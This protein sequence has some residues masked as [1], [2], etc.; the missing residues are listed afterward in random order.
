MNNQE[1]GQILERI[2]ALLQLSD[3]N[4]FKIRAYRQAAHS[5][6]NL[7]C[8]LYDLYAQ[9]RLREISGVGKTV[10]AHIEEILK[11]GASAY[12]EELSRQIPETVVDMLRV[13][14]LG[15]KTVVQLY[16]ELGIDNLADLKDSARA[17]R[18]RNLPGVGPKTEARILQG[19]QVLQQNADKHSI[20]LALPMAEKLREHL[21]INM[22]ETEVEIVGSLRRGKP[23]VS[24]VDILVGTL[25]NRRVGQIT[26]KL[27]NLDI[28][29][30][31]MDRIAGLLPSQIPFEIILVNPE[32]F[33]YH[34]FTSTGS[35]SHRARVL[36]EISARPDSFCDETQIYHHCH[37]SYIPPE[38]REDRGEIE[39]ARDNRLP[40]PVSLGDIKGDLHMHSNW[41]DGSE[42]LIDLMAAARARGYEYLAITDHSSSLPIT[43]GLDR[44]RLRMQGHIIAELNRQPGPRLL[45]GIECEILKDGSLDIVDDELKQLDV[46]IASI[47]SH[48]RLDRQAQTERLLRVIENPHVDIIGHLTGRMLNRRPGYELDLERILQAVQRHKKV[49]EINSHPYR[50][51][52]DEHITRQAVSLGIKLAVN[53]DAHNR[54]ELELLRY[55]ILSARRGWAQ[56]RDVINTWSLAEI[57]AYFH[58][59]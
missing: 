21:R 15:P 58:S 39:A 19:L 14:G 33:A 8:D 45:R 27:A 24:D 13:P 53:S 48:F 42:N 36:E 6:Y 44:E 7:E 57:M 3:E 51:D 31:E 5:I 12:L 37:L 20:G 46:V 38:L 59:S 55:G 10:Q 52:I 29:E 35:K 32:E 28:R 2:A 50:L 26:S 1:V 22:P 30:Q 40:Q 41:S 17:G 47:H 56:A 25:D 16:Q 11:T 34:L 54:S 18:L 49:L 9:K 43:G 23:L 4:P